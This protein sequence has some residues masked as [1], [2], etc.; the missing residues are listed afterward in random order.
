MKEGKEKMRMNDRLQNY[1]LET[2]E[3]GGGGDCFFKSIAHRTG[4]S[5][6]KVRQGT[7]NQLR[8][9]ASAYD[10]LG[11]F[12]EI[13][14]YKAFCDKVGTPGVFVDGNA[15]IAAAADF[16]GKDI[17]I[18]GRDEGTDVF[19]RKGNLGAP[20]TGDAKGKAI[21][22]AYFMQRRALYCGSFNSE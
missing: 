5:H 1:G 11:N 22:L 19:I 8:K 3:R 4:M 13:G 9:V 12:K 15:E 7:A 20:T 6:S 17:F 18:I 10:K 2:E 16:I 21:I 14:G